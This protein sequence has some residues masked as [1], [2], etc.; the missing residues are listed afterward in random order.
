MNLRIKIL[1]L[2]FLFNLSFCYAG[3]G[4]GG[5]IF[6][7]VLICLFI[8]L[9]LTLFSI[10]PLVFFVK[11]IRTPQEDKSTRVY[12][13]SI[14]GIIF[15]LYRFLHIYNSKIEQRNKGDYKDR[16][17]LKYLWNNCDHKYIEE[18]SVLLILILINIYIVYK[19]YKIDRKIT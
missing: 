1:L 3:D 9:I 6:L 16:P 10:L 19:T 5:Y 4:S 2:L 18:L 12:F 7:G 8:L 15:Y 14:I 13:F 17:I 11:Y